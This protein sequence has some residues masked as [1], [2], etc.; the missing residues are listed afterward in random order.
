MCSPEKVTLPKVSICIPAY[1]QPE[2]LLRVLKSVIIQTFNDY[3]VVITDDSP[4]NSVA[5]VVEEFRERA[6]IRYYKNKSRKGSPENWN[7]AIRLASGEYIKIL[8][9]D[10]W[11]SDENSL[12]EF[13][14]M[15]D[16]NPKANF[17]FC[18]SQ[19]CGADGKLRYVNTASE[20]QIK[21]LCA[22]PS[23]LFRGNFIGAPSATIYRR[24]VDQEFDSRMK[25]LVDIDFYIHVLSDKREFINIGRPLVCVSLE[26][27]GK[28]TD[29]CLG[30]KRLEVFEY[31][32][33]YTKLAKERPLDY[34][35]CQ[36]IWTLFD[37]FNVQSARDILD[38]GVDFALPQEVK[39][40]LLFRRICKR[41]GRRLASAGMVFLY[42]YLKLTHFKR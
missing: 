3:E 35:R 8:H 41:A 20:V 34:Q 36:V 1:K 37:R 19:N 7:E 11:F 29:E 40:I 18:P 15:L 9:H 5:L 10:D 13:V 42:P 17:A 21:M 23:V 25:W 28:V 6:N 24:P 32:Y 22:D 30:N 33:L 16:R 39:D 14:D 38:C 2:N 27:P 12:A 26:S 31:L 4:D